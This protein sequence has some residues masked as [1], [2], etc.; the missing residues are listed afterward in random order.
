MILRL[1]REPTVDASTFGVLLKNGHFFAFT[2]EDAIREVPN[3]PV[4]T[5]KVP[6]QTAIPAGTYRIDVT[7]S[8]RFGRKLPILLG[9]PGFSGIRIH[10]LNNS[11][12]TEG[13]IGVGLDRDDKNL[14]LLRSA[15]AVH[16][17]QDYIDAA[18]A[19]GERVWIDIENPRPA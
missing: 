4:E 7:H 14:R 5:W 11:D 2:L 9:V 16:A 10:P 17:L 12:E 13:C 18:I 6:G 1:I 15:V 19:Q 8:P 3:Q